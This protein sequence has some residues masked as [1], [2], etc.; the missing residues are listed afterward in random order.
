MKNVIGIIGYGGKMGTAL[1]H[2]IPQDIVLKLGQR[3]IEKIMRENVEY[4]K[5]DIYKQEEVADFT[6]N[7]DILINCAGPSMKILDL[8]ADAASKANIPYVDAFGGTL[9][10]K[11]LEQKKIAGSFIL[12]AGSFPGLTACLPIAIANKYFDQVE[13]INITL[14]NH[15]N[16]GKASALD[17]VF[18][19]LDH[20]GKANH[21]YFNG[22]ILPCIIDKK[23]EH[24][25]FIETEYINQETISIAKRMN[26]KEAHFI[27]I[28]DNSNC[29][30]ELQKLMQ[31]YIIQRDDQ[32]LE[33]QLSELQINK[34]DH[35]YFKISCS[36]EGFKDQNGITVN[37]QLKFPNSYV[38]GAII[39]LH[40]IQELLV[41]KNEIGIKNAYEILDCNK[42]LDDCEKLGNE[43][44]IN[45]QNAVE[46]GEI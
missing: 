29:E 37:E 21:F 39:I 4:Q 36:I 24:N 40:C 42:V 41:L 27:Q 28:R 3:H 30:K 1:C 17:L 18:S 26:A 32:Q 35:E 34:I 8:V 7:I 15:E 9:L 11:K 43:R 10:E 12:N 33:K 19:A 6:K 20:Y 16:W 31:G 38:A 23:S 2:L 46:E 25:D 13:K 5:V 44:I 22:K 45:I 14:E